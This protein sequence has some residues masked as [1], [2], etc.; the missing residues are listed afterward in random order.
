MRDKIIVLIFIISTILV[1]SLALFG[2]KFGKIKILSVSDIIDENDAVNKKIKQATVLAETTYPREL[3]ELQET[4]DEYKI[5]RQ[6]Y[7]E[8]SEL[9]SDEDNIY[10][11]EKYDI[12]YLWTTLGKMASKN[13]VDLSL[14]VVKSEGIG[15]YNLEFAIQGEY[16]DIS[17]FIT[18][19]ENNSDL[20]FRIYNFKLTPGA[21]NIKLK[22]TFT[23]RDVNIEEKSLIKESSK[24]LD[25]SLE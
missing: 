20:Y 1:I 5:Q 15:L 3:R 23:V 21:S 17:S 19:I 6:K 16:V 8:I 2:F 24:L 18:T 13:K 14:N 22:A 10:E 4:I 9:D 11:T 12:G 25:N 7:E